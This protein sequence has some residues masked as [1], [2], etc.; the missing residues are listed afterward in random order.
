MVLQGLQLCHGT[1]WVENPR[2]V[3]VLKT[4]ET[5]TG[6][7]EGLLTFFGGESVSAVC[8]LYILM[9]AGQHKG[10]QDSPHRGKH[11]SALPCPPPASFSYAHVSPY[12]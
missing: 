11:Q 7:S 6:M 1:D 10:L 3:V 4:P 9:L 8:V 2:Y 5:K 12:R